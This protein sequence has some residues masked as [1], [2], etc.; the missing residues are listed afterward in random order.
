M[1]LPHLI[2]FVM[3]VFGV[4]Y[5]SI[6]APAPDDGPNFTF[7]SNDKTKLSSKPDTRWTRSKYDVTP[8]SRDDASSDDITGD[9]VILRQREDGH[10]YTFADVDGGEV[11]FLVDTGATGIALT[12]KDAHNLGLNW[13][14]SEL[15]PV[16]R[17]AGGALY[18]KPVMLSSVSVGDFTVRNVQAVIL[19]HGLDV[20][21]LGQS[22]LSSV[23]NVT[24]SDG[25]MIL[26]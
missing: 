8:R 23:P 22:F 26:Q 14:D 18:G 25:Q 2:V 17:G 12:G 21:L 19:P 6:P 13:T 15:Q 1:K 7:G 24:I 16:G 10:Y 5:C 9:A 11:H 3:L 20:S 4:S